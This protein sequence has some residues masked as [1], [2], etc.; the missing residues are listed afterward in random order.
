MRLLGIETSDNTSSVALSCDGQLHAEELFH[1]RLVLC[2]QLT[3]RILRILEGDWNLLGIAVSSGPGSFTG[4][5]IG[6]S[7]AKALGHVL[8]VPVVGVPTQHV[9]AA[10]CGPLAD[11]VAVVQKARVGHVY[12]GVYHVEPG[13]LFELQ[14]VQ[15]LA[16]E[17]VYDHVRQA[18]VAV[19]D[20]LAEAVGSDPR[21]A[22]LQVA[23]APHDVP[24]ASVVLRLASWPAEYSFEQMAAL[25]PQYLLASQAE[26]IHGI[27][28]D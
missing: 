28:V 16:F 9:L 22:D 1:S 25:R 10:G 8:G 19:G 5:R 21:L 3:P 7:T 4:L 13:G 12:A 17:Q 26:R 23:G 15:L 18:L 27:E 11:S 6:V 20:G 24:R 2:D 14:P